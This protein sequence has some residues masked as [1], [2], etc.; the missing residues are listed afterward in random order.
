MKLSKEEFKALQTHWYEKAKESG[1]NDIE[2][3]IKRDLS[4][5]FRDKSQLE[6]ATKQEYYQLIN[7]WVYDETTQFRNDFDKHVMRLHAEGARIKDIV[8]HLH[9]LGGNHGRQV[10]RLIIRRYEMKWKI[11]YYTRKQLNLK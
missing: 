8:E 1:F 10:V 4:C 2:P 5:F 3:E 7:Q 9:A 6:V 11:R